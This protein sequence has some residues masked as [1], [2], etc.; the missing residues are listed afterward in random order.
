[1]NDLLSQFQSVFFNLQMLYYI[2]VET[3]ED[4]DILDMVS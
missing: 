1:M 4:E 3:N 2:A